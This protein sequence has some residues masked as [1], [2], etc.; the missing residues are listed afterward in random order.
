M[1]LAWPLLAWL[2]A[3]APVPTAGLA[4]AGPGE[5]VMPP[6][7]ETAKLYFLAGDLAKAVEWA[8]RGVRSKKPSDV[9]SCRPLLK[10]LAEYGFLAP[11]ADDFTVQ[12]AHDFIQYDRAISPGTP[13]KLTTPIIERFVTRPLTRAAELARTPSRS[14]DARQ[15]LENVLAVDPTNE[16]AAQL[17]AALTP[18]NEP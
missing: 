9:K 10:A 5:R 2:A 7:S 1:T 14:S 15:V 17:R 18:K 11:H 13:G 16:A 4:D 3:Q 12:Q 8:T 6:F